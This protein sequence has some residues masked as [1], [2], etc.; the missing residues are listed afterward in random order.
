M[1]RVFFELEHGEL[2]GNSLAARMRETAERVADDVVF[3]IK[4]KG[5]SKPSHAQRA[6]ADR[7]VKASR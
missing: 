5:P 6:T 1:R 3:A 4:T 2:N 7:A